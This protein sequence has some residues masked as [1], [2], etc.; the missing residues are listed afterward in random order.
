MK[1]R[2]NDTKYFIIIAIVIF[3]FSCSKRKPVMRNHD[4]NIIVLNKNAYE[5]Q[6]KKFTNTIS[7][8]SF[9]DMI[10]KM[11]NIKKG[12]DEIL[13]NKNSVSFSEF[14]EVEILDTLQQNVFVEVAE[15]YKTITNDSILKTKLDIDILQ[16]ILFYTAAEY[17]N[18]KY[19]CDLAYHPPVELSNTFKSVL[20]EYGKSES[21]LIEFVNPYEPLAKDV[22]DKGGIYHI[23][24]TKEMLT[25]LQ[26]ELQ[27]QKENIKNSSEISNDLSYLNEIFSKGIK[28]ESIIIMQFMP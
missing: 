24:L 20:Q 25:I 11:L 28:S 1:N 7:T 26:R 2:R 12:T 15:K 19:Y 27:H 14:Y 10:D 13:I 18:S 6:F 5:E 23:A 16:P 21:N 8:S 17:F 3:L 4:I 9:R 22:A